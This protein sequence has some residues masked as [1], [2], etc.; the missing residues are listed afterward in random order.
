MGKGEGAKKGSIHDWCH[1]RLP[2]GLGLINDRA[3]CEDVSMQSL[4]LSFPCTLSV[5]SSMP[6]TQTLRICQGALKIQR[7]TLTKS[8]P[9]IYHISATRDIPMRDA[10]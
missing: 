3:S 1:L 8:L 4:A 10:V 7:K 6:K 9:F 2:K 5:V